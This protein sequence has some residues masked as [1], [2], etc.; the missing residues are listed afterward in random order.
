MIYLF[1]PF[2]KIQV[3]QEANLCN[4]WLCL[5]LV[6]AMHMTSPTIKVRLVYVC[7]H[8]YAHTFL[9]TLVQTHIVFLYTLWQIFILTWFEL[10]TTHSQIKVVSCWLEQTSFASETKYSTA[11]NPGIWCHQQGDESILFREGQKTRS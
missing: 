5:T 9:E 2:L 4:C 3:L 11:E 6:K 8:V 10:F 1:F 7:V